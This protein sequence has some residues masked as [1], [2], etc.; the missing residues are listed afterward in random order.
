[1][2]ALLK[3]SLYLLRQVTFTGVA[4]LVCQDVSNY[5]EILRDYILKPR[6]YCCFV[7]CALTGFIIDAAAKCIKLTNQVI[8]VASLG[9]TTNDRTHA[10]IKNFGDCF[11]IF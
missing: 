6:R 3:S 4:E 9:E 7:L 8:N 11:I 10:K 5:L 2:V 1:M